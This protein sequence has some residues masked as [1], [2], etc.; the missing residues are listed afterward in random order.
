MINGNAMGRVVALRLG[1]VE[2]IAQMG[3]GGGGEA[4][5]LR[6]EGGCH[7][8]GGAWACSWGGGVGECG[9]GQGVVVISCC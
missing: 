4:G 3:D 9:G 1:N 7:G 6:G 5:A 8:E 2:G